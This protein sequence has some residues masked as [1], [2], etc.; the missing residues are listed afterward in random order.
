M[1]WNDVLGQETAI[2]LLQHHLR[3]GRVAQ[4]Y[5]LVGPE[6][7]G[8]RR[9]ATELAKALNCAADASLRPCDACVTCRQISRGAHP[10]VH[11]V[12]PEGPAAQIKIEPIRALIAQVALRPFNAATHVV[13]IDGAERLTEE[14]ANSLLKTL[15]EPSPHTRF[16]LTTA[17]PAHCLPTVVSR[18]Q[19]L[20]CRRL[21]TEAVE[22][23]VRARVDAEQ[24][25]AV[26]VARLAAGSASHA[27][28][29]AKRWEA[30]QA[31]VARCADEPKAWMSSPLP[32][33]REE[34]MPW[35][36]AMMAWVRDVAVA[37]VSPRDEPLIHREQ[38]HVLRRQ[39]RSV[40]LDQC[41]EAGF[42]LAALRESLEE[43]GNP[44]LAAALAREEW[45]EL[46]N[47]KREA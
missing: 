32:E 21:S 19:V 18:C 14:A 6:G 16:M 10:D 46:T 29:L 28:A 4:A 44:R 36:E 27:I 1:A 33:T 26:T 11:T 12:S 38:A 31:I 7:V 9:L 3:T 25:P 47:V 15:E 23:I 34:L 39:A 20:R 22:R 5:L 45:L 13:V 35:L 24:V 43:F 30:R 37:A 2:R 17:H 41:L 40:P 8:K 42:R